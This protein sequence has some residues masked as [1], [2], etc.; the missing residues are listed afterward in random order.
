MGI[1]ICELVFLAG[2]K[3]TIDQLQISG[4]AV[5][6]KEFYNLGLDFAYGMANS[7]IYTRVWRPFIQVNAFYNSEIGNFSYN[8]NLGYGGKVFSQDHMIV[9]ANYTES[10]NGVGGNVFELFLR[11]QF[12]YMNQKM[13]NSFK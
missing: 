10:V 3:G 6:P 5:L 4:T 8:L 11:Y 9:G 13:F 2:R 1:Q 7:N 12:L